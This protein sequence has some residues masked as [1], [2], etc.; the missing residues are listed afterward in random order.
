MAK[1][2]NGLNAKLVLFCILL[3]NVSFL[4]ASPPP[5]PPG[6]GG[7][8]ASSGT[9]TSESET[10]LASINESDHFHEFS[11]FIEARAGIRTNNDALQ[12]DSSLLESRAQL[13]LASEWSIT[14]SQSVKTNIGAD[15]L[16]DAIEEHHEP[17]LNQGKGWF[18]LRELNAIYSPVQSIDLKIGRQILTWGTGDLIFINDLFPKDWHSFFIGRDTEYLKAPSDA[19]KIAYFHSHFNLDII[20]TPQFDSDRFIDGRRISYFS[21]LSNASAGRAQTLVVEKPDDWFQD[22]EIALRLYRNFSSYEGALYAY[23]GFWKS[24]NGFNTATGNAVFPALKVFGAS[25]RGPFAAGIL[26]AEWAFYDSLDDNNGSN[27]F[28]RNSEQRFLIGYEQEVAAELTG[29]VQ[30]YLE[31]RV[32]QSNYMLNQPIGSPI[33][34]QN[35]QVVTLRLTQ[36]LMNQNLLLSL[37]NFYSPTDSDGYLRLKGNYKLTDQWQLEGGANIFYG[38]KNNTFFAQFEDAANV[39]TSV[40]FL[41]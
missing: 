35:R 19:I 15:V 31:H 34:D 36:L 14:N 23:N 26:N 1:A 11:G 41:Y 22:D 21:P 30:F 13:H 29:A 33:A 37:F 17:A 5:L 10:S 2:L 3:G 9:S 18:D 24:P 40:R 12:R 38:N 25:V 7:K 8:T 39:Y 6:L 20:L 32:N 4:L 16:Y 27:P 28:I